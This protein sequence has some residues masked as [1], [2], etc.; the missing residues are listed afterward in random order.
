M[1][2]SKIIQSVSL[3]LISREEKILCYH[4]KD[5]ISKDIFFRLIGGHIDFGES[6][7]LAL[8]R[9]F[10]EE[11]GYDANGS[12]TTEVDG[13]NM[14]KISDTNSPEIIEKEL[15][16]VRVVPEDNITEVEESFESPADTLQ[17]STETE[18]ELIRLTALLQNEFILTYPSIHGGA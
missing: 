16:K 10:K 17:V 4:V 11:V 12:P 7:D 18:G 8:E 1:K 13:D 6:A 2:Q 14:P 9:E 3:G 15:E 5:K